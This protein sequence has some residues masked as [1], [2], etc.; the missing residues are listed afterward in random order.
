MNNLNMRFVLIPSFVTLIL[1]LVACSPAL[2]ATP[3]LPDLDYLNEHL[4]PQLTLPEGA[5]PLGGG[6]GGGNYGMGIETNFVSDLTIEVVN[7]HYA[8]QLVAAGWG[9]IS[10]ERSKKIATSFW[11]VTDQSGSRWA[12]K[13][14]VTLDPPNFPDTYRVK[15]AILLPQ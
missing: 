7:Q 1:F 14:E 9:L 2:I 6:G 12:G 15:V 13:L 4:V 11:E 10:E 5:Q 3:T 8:D